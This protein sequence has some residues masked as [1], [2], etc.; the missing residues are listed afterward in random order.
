MSIE[1]SEWYFG[2]CVARSVRNNQLGSCCI[3]IDRSS[4]NN[5]LGSGRNNEVVVIDIDLDKEAVEVD[6]ANELDE[7]NEANVADRTN[8]ANEANKA[9]LYDEA[10][11]AVESN[12][13]NEAY[14][15]G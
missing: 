8:L 12:V 7:T 3:C 2:I 13:S 9:S 15:A 1:S 5:Q 6:E 10:D 11:N 14:L 4:H